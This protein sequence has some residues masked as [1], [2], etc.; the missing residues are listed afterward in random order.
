M[1]PCPAAIDALSGRTHHRPSVTS[2]RLLSGCH[3]QKGLV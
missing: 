1:P 2:W 3:G